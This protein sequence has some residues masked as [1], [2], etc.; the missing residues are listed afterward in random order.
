MLL[1]LMEILACPVDHAELVLNTLKHEGDDVEEGT[2]TCSQ[3]GH[4]YRIENGIPN[5]LP[6]VFE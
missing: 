5:L 4:V 3:C 2:L 1:E 6:P